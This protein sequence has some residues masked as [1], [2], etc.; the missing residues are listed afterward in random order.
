MI[1]NAIPLAAAPKP[2]NGK[3]REGARLLLT[4]H[5]GDDPIVGRTDDIQRKCLVRLLV[6][7]FDG[8]LS[9]FFF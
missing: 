1:M 8:N 6:V 5:R 4:P 3:E 9:P 2:N 7:V